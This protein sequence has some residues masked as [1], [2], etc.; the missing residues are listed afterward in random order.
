[1][2]DGQG[3]IVAADRLLYI[4][5]GCEFHGFR[6]IFVVGSYEYDLEIN[7]PD[8]LQQV[9][10]CTAWKHDIQEYQVR[11]LPDDHIIGC[12]RITADADDRNAGVDRGH[13]FRN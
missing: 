6:D 5:V 3:Q 1:M 12:G 4:P 9:E 13:H 7:I 8:A 10:T 2:A 11:P